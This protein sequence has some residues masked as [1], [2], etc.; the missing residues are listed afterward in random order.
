MC[1]HVNADLQPNLRIF[2]THYC[3]NDTE[4]YDNFFTIVTNMFVEVLLAEWFSPLCTKKN[5][6][7]FQVISFNKVFTIDH[8]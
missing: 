3:I 8:P 7:I 1:V 2:Y 5:K 6:I 4:Y